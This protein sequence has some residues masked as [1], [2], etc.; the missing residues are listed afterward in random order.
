MYWILNL[1]LSKNAKSNLL[2]NF[3]FQKQRSQC[4]RDILDFLQ[5]PLLHFEFLHRAFEDIYK[6]TSTDH[7]D[8]VALQSVVDKFAEA[9]SVLC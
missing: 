4:D 1:S 3:I 8:F 7:P 5:Q 2:F 9:F 6:H